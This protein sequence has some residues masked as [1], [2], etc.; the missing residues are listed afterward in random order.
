MKN[1]PRMSRIRA[2]ERV[3]LTR[4]YLRVSATSA[5]KF[6]LVPDEHIHGLRRF[7][8]MTCGEAAFNNLPNLRNLWIGFRCHFAMGS[9]NS[10]VSSGTMV[11]QFKPSMH[12]SNGLS[13]ATARP[14]EHLW[15]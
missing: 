14:P 3:H 2:D 6:S 11:R 5:V 8:Q 15:I 13:Q 4:N 1:E 10:A 7:S 12:R 9:L